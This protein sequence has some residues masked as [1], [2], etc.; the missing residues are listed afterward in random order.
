[1][2]G[3][4]LTCAV[5]QARGQFHVAGRVVDSLRNGLEF[6]AVALVSPVGSSVITGAVS[7]S[8]GRF[9]VRTPRPGAYR[10]RVSMVGYET[11][12]REIILPGDEE[13]GEITLHRSNVQL[14]A[15]TITPDLIEQFPDRYVVKMQG[16]PIARGANIVEAL[17]MLPGVTT[18]GGGT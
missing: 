10:V 12:I 4:I 16:N 1:L 11:A 14:Q 13:V 9:I 6:C 3:V 15:V 7:D 18:R 2:I 5:A 17:G 8:L